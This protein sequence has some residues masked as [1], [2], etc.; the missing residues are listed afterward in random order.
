[1][2]KP[3]P[4]RQI[5]KKI[6]DEDFKEHVV[7]LRA[8]QRIKR[9]RVLRITVRTVMGIAVLV[10]GFLLT[11][12]LLR[13]SEHPLPEE[14]R[15]TQPATE[16]PTEPIT[17]PEPEGPPMH[18]F[19]VPLNMLDNRGQAHELV[20]QAQAAKTNAAVMPF[21]DSGGYL[22]YRSNLMQMRLIKASQKTRYRTDW[23]L[24]DLKKAGQR[25]IAVIHC[26][27][28][29]LAAGTMMEAAVLQRDTDSVPWKD[30]QGRRW[31]NPWSEPAR[32]Y[33]LAVI[34]EVVAFGADDILLAGVC[35]P[36]GNLQ[37]AVFPGQEEPGDPL[38]RNQI[39]RAF[40][41]EAKEAAGGNA[42]LYVMIPSHAALN[43]AEELGGDLWDCAADWIAIDMRD[44]PW[45]QD[46]DYW[47]ARP[48]IPVVDDA[49]KAQG[50]RD[51]IVLVD[52]A[53]G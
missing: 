48:V 50:A 16:P 7:G 32:E 31:L 23:T 4:K 38:A 25:I 39:L 10:I 49:E 20:A 46:A 2:Q 37:A 41:G 26:F 30:S 21:K 47:R 52:E 51:Y 33:L 22:S 13:V 15:T 27:D 34:R 3:I 19:Y 24:K 29:P 5:H 28:D 40:I 8:R 42:A 35:F 44:A 17:R 9:R 6:S 43:G 12:A 18:S 11:D 1:M 14:L 53:Q 36:V 45:A